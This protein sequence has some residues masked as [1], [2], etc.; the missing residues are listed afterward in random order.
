M[1]SAIKHFVI[2]GIAASLLFVQSCKDENGKINIF[3]V[4]DD[5]SFG[6]QVSAEFEKDPNNKILDSASH[7]G[8][9]KYV[10]GI[11]DSILNTG[12]LTYGNTF[13]WRMRVI[14]DDTTL[15]A[16]CTPGGYIYVYTGLMKFL[17]S[18]DQLAGVLGH[19]MAHADRRHST[20]AMTREY[21][22]Q[23]LI[24]IVFGQD[25]GQLVRIA[26][27]LKSLQY[28]R[29]N[30]TQADEYSVI[31]LYPTAYNAYGAA[32]F[33]EKMIALGSQNPPE[34]LST[35][36]NPDNRVQAI[37]DKWMSLGGKAGNDFKTRYT[38]FLST[39]P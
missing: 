3:T 16:F 32:G 18:E 14:Q 33:F 15:N 17:E 11:R 26:A 27:G 34:F 22:I 35:H 31:Y 21:G 28:S 25:K 6:A 4:Q 30:E 8:I 29:Q 7:V 13:V 38:N 10:Y 23:T 5:M 1:K 9:Y 37:K 12:K 19:E 2:A 20:E 36:P 24:D 39:L